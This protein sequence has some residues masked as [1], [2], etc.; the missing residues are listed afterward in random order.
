MEKNSIHREYSKNQNKVQISLLPSAQDPNSKCFIT[1]FLLHK[2][3][4]KKHIV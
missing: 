3:F 1:T 4:E 2:V